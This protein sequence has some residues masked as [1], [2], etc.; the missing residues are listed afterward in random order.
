MTEKSWRWF[1]QQ[2][3]N[4]SATA[5]K[6]VPPN[7]PKFHASRPP[8]ATLDDAASQYSADLAVSKSQLEASMASIREG[9]AVKCRGSVKTVTLRSRCGS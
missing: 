7:T 9:E 3:K 8:F 1:A 4:R 2:H 6:F 5:F